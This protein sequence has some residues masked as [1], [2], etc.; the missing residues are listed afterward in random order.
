MRWNYFWV[1]CLILLVCC[2]VVTK[3]QDL[4][5]SIRE[6][7]DSLDKIAPDSYKDVRPKG[8]VY[9]IRVKTQKDFDV[10]NTTITEAITVGKTNIR[11][12]IGNGVFHFRE[13]QIFRSDDIK[14]NVSIV[15]E[16]KKRTIITS[17]ENSNND[18]SNIKSP[19]LEMNYSDGPI[20]VVN[21]EDKLCKIPYKNHLNVKEK[22]N[23]NKVQI[24]E[25]FRST[26]YEVQ[27]IDDTG[28]Y[29][30]ASDLQKVSI[31]GRSGFNVNYDYLYSQNAPRFRLLD[32]D[33]VRSC[34]AARMLYMERCSYRQFCLKGLHFVSNKA[35]GSLITLNDVQSQGFLVSGCT[36]EHIRGTIMNASNSA[37]ITFKKNIVSNTA[38]DELRFLNN[39]TNVR[40]NNNSFANCGQ[41]ISNS[42]CVNCREADYY[43]ANNT[44]C[45]FGYCA[46]GVGIWHGFEKKSYSGGIIEHNEIYFTPYYF[47][48]AWKYMLMDS[49]AIYTWTQNDEVIIRY[50]YIHDYTGAGDNRGIFCD[51]GACNL[52]IYG[53]F[54]LNVSNS[55]CI[56]SRMSKDQHYGFTNN[57]NNLIAHNVVDGS[58]RFQGYGDKERHSIKGANYVVNGSKTEENEFNNLSVN[59][60]D[61][62][63]QR[64]HVEKLSKKL[65]NYKLKIMY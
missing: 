46:I 62:E 49:G 28:I 1:V 7:L 26:V 35:G 13:N 16:G 41:S 57:A 15:I 9:T 58:V 33:I 31:N 32:T 52:K 17:D 48:E 6:K 64:G 44:F 53:N 25:W 56:D 63:I 38:G 21:V 40:V 60:Q 29:F 61:I 43:I 10:I 65:K 54:V 19:W 22:R 55:Y 4:D 27:N 11:V 30:F 8:C 3:G 20:E 36:F 50:N 47:A 23:L 59:L 24:T 34:S 39:C 37:N 42:F 18:L 45:D 51:D 14:P 12:I 5:A 2:N